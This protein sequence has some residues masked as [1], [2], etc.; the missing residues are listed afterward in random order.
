MHVLFIH[1]NFPAQFGQLAEYLVTRRGWQATYLTSVD[2]TALNLPFNHVNYRLNDGPQPKSFTN[3]DTLQGLTDHLLA[4]YRGMRN[5]QQLP[6]PDLVVGH[7]SYGTMLYLRNLYQCPFIGFFE[8]YPPPF[9]TDQMILRREFP[10]TEGVR[11]F[12]STYHALTALHLLMVDGAYTP[13]AFQKSTAPP[14]FRNKITVLHEGVPTDLFQGRRMVRPTTFHNIPIGPQTKVVTFVSRGLESVRG[15]DIFMKMAAR[16]AQ[17][18]PDVLFLIA[19]TDKTFYGHEQLHI[20]QQQSFKQY[21][22]SQGEYDPQK[23][24]FLDFIDLKELATLFNL[25]D[26]HVYLTVPY[27]LSQSLIQAMASECLILSSATAPVQE[28]IKDGH[29]G[30]L[31]DFYDVDAL[32]RRAL[33]MLRSPDD[34][35]PLRQAARERALREHDRLKCLEATAQFFQLFSGRARDR[36]FENMVQEKRS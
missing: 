10:P 22:L 8:L 27:V 17:E 13:T 9:W 11:L 16:V 7:M 5:A 4:I 21:V 12:H 24:H 31:V 34:F 20:G 36:L 26:L 25:S 35:L 33:E 28:V 6:R 23:F 29:E 30:L 19:G 14:E 18:I 1:P 32:T 2:T 15:F 3:P